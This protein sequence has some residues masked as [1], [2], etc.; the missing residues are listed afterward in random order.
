MP[1]GRL[2]VSGCVAV[3]PRRETF[4]QV[5]MDPQWRFLSLDDSGVDFGQQ[6]G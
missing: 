3:A 6:G 4:E 5:V 1:V 2:V